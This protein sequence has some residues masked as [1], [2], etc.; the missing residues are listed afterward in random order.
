MTFFRRHS[1][2]CCFAALAAAL[3]LSGTAHAASNAEPEPAVTT[4]ENLNWDIV[5]PDLDEPLAT[6]RATLDNL[7]WD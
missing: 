4:A 1:S 7:N 2:A 3:L 6:V 5:V